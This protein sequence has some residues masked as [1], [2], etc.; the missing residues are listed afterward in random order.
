MN[1]ILASMKEAF[2]S[3]KFVA[4]FSGAIMAGAL[5]LGLEM[6][7][8][9]V[10]IILSPFITYILAQGVADQGKSAAKVEAVSRA[11]AEDIGMSTKESV[12]AIQNT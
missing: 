9:D 12:K 3:K 1:P 8:A 2:T 11:V 5:K 4:A 7:T 6:S 10:A